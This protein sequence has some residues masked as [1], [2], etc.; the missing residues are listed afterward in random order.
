MGNQVLEA[1][2]RALDMAKEEK[3]RPVEAGVPV[4]VLSPAAAEWV[5]R[6][7]AWPSHRIV[8]AQKIPNHG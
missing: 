1:F 2:H 3:Q 7:G 8:V 5:R 4:L 6:E